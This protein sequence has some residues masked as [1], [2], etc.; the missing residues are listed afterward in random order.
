MQEDIARS[1]TLLYPP[2]GSGHDAF[3]ST[4]SVPQDGDY[5]LN[6]NASYTITS[7]VPAGGTYASVFI[8]GV[9]LN[10]VFK[11]VVADGGTWVR[12][13]DNKSEIILNAG[14]AA[15]VAGVGS[16]VTKIPLLTT[17]TVSIGFGH[18][19]QPTATF[20]A[21]MALRQLSLLRVT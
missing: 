9:I 13:W 7:G 18:V 16:F 4:L 6:F 14:G 1:T 12:F 20:T 15:G 2:A 3:T 5:Q 8:V 19:L 21:N 10:G 11:T 17:D